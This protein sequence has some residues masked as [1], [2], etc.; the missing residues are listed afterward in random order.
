[1]TA[2]RTNAASRAQRMREKATSRTQAEVQT[3]APIPKLSPYDRLL[4][5]LRGDIATR[6]D[7]QQR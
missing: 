3:D 7:N 1:M 2:K 4:A 5:K 6:N